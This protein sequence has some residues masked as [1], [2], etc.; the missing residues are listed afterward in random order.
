MGIIAERK[1]LTRKIRYAKTIFL[2]AHKDLDL[3]ALG[4]SIGMYMILKRRHKKCY[5]II[6][7]KN[8]ELGVEKVLRELE[9]CI[10]IIKSE[11]ID[12]YLA[13]RDRKNLLI[14]LDTNKEDLVQNKEV[15][16]KIENKVII[17]HHETGPTTIKDA[18]LIIDTNSSSVCE[19]I[20]QLIEYY[21]VDIESYYA[22]ILL[23]GIVLDTNNFTL[24]TKPE[25]YYS[26]YYL[27]SL[28][29]SAKKVQYLLK[30]ELAEYYSQILKLLMEKLLLRKQHH[31]LFIVV[32]TW[33]K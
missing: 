7:D 22:T 10:D 25:T 27:A 32:K 23:A 31:I 19:M 2:M 13:P 4:S 8:H 16:S 11:E 20:T 9:G 33:L 28:G 21:D 1:K 18:L 17:D 30:Q 24:K 15:L 29:G 14:V 6:D 26:A 3:D 12:A 5:L